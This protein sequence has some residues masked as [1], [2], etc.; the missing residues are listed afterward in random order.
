MKKN[1][2]INWLALN[3]SDLEK[4]KKIKFKIIQ[5]NCGSH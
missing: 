1:R 3:R 4:I 5:V 2:R